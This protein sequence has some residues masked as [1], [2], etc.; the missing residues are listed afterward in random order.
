MLWPRRDPSQA[1]S[2][3]PGGVGQRLLCLAVVSLF[4]GDTWATVQLLQPPHTFRGGGAP[5]L[6]RFIFYLLVPL[7]ALVRLR[8]VPAELLTRPR[9]HAAR[10]TWRDVLDG[11][12]FVS[13][14]IAVVAA[15]VV[16]VAD[17]VLTAQSRADL[18]LP[19]APASTSE[20]PVDVR[21][22]GLPTNPEPAP[23]EQCAPPATP[24]LADLAAFLAGSAT[25]KRKYRRTKPQAKRT[26]RTRP[27]PFAAIWDDIRQRLEAAPE[28][29]A[30]VIV[31]ELQHAYPGQ[32]TDGQ[33]RTLQRRVKMWRA[34]AVLHFDQHWLEEE[35]VPAQVLPAALTARTARRAE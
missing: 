7:A 21:G 1:P 16:I 19:A 3:K 4:V 5:N 9:A 22:C 34:Q 20:L 6:F 10:L 17:A 11:I 24:S 29:T 31:Q 33:L 8:L 25:T 27:D 12:T 15:G 32:Y 28:R 18:V 23:T 2:R 26:W 13:P 14:S 35:L 30:K